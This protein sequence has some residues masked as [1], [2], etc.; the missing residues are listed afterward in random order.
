MYVSMY[1]RMYVC[2]ITVALLTTGNAWFGFYISSS[3]GRVVVYTRTRVGFVYVRI[4]VVHG[5]NSV[6]ELHIEG[7]Y[8]HNTFTTYADFIK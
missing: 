6:L 2:M 1:V 4:F 3:I 7:Q 8:S 5:T